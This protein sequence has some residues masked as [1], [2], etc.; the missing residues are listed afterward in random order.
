MYSLF[1]RSWLSR[2]QCIARRSKNVQRADGLA[3]GSTTLCIYTALRN[4]VAIESTPSTSGT[5]DSWLQTGRNGSLLLSRPCPLEHHV[6]SSPVTMLW[7]STKSV[8]VRANFRCFM[9]R[10]TAYETHE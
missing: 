9:T 6:G 10:V 8:G 4:Q 2:R 5:F 3:V 1:F 7:E